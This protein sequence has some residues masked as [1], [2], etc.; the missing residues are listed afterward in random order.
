MRDEHVVQLDHKLL[1]EMLQSA[2]FS[3]DEILALEY[4]TASGQHIV[5]AK[6]DNFP[7]FQ[8]TN[9]Q[10]RHGMGRVGPGSSL[11]VQVTKK[12]ATPLPNNSWI[13][14]S[15]LR[16]SQC[17]E[18]ELVA[19][20]LQLVMACA[21][22]FPGEHAT[23]RLSDISAGL[24][25]AR[26][27][28]FFEPKRTPTGIPLAFVTIVFNGIDFLG[29]HYKVFEEAASR[30]GV[31]FEWHIVEGVAEGRADA[32]KP[33]SDTS[34][35]A[36]YGTESNLSTDGT[37]Q[38]LDSISKKHRN[39][40]VYR[41][42]D[43]PFKDKI[44]QIN[45]A[46]SHV[47]KSMLMQVDVDELWSTDAIV[48]AYKVL[49][50]PKEARKCMM[51]SCHFFVGPGRVVVRGWGHGPSEW[52]RAWKFEPGSFF[53]SH[54]PPVL[55]SPN[56]AGSLEEI[57]SC[58]SKE[59]TKQL[60]IG[61]SHYAYMFESQVQFKEEFY[62]YSEAV[63][64]W[65]ALQ[66]AELPVK[67]NQY[68]PW[69][70][71]GAPNYEPRFEE[72]L[73]VN[74]DD[75]DLTKSIDVVELEW[76]KEEGTDCSLTVMVDGVA[77]QM[78][79]QGG[80]ARVWSEVLPKVVDNLEGSCFVYLMRG[81]ERIPEA[82][83]ES[84]GRRVRHV[85][86][87]SFP[88]DGNYKAL[89]EDT[90]MLTRLAEQYGA[91]LFISTEYTFPDAL[92]IPTV[93]LVHDL[94][95]EVF[96]WSEDY[97]KL[98][99]EAIERASSIVT[100][101]KST[102]EKLRHFYRPAVQV[103]SSRNG[104]DP[105]VFFKRGKEA[106][107]RVREEVNM[108]DGDYLL[109]V[110]QRGGYKSTHSLTQT[111]RMSM[112]GGKVSARPAIIFVGGGSFTDEEVASL[113]GLAAYH[114]LSPSDDTLA[115]LYSGAAALVYLSL[116]EGFGLPLIE[117]LACGCGVIASDIEVFREV[118]GAYSDSVLFVKPDDA[119]GIVGAVHE[120]LKK[121]VG[122]ETMVKV[123]DAY[124]VGWVDLADTVTEA[125][126]EIV[127]G[128]KESVFVS[129]QGQDVW[130]HDAFKGLRGPAGGRWFV[131][132]GAND[133][134][135]LSNT[136]GLEKCGGWFGVCIEP[137]AAFDDL[138]ASG[139]VKCNKV[140]EAIAGNARKATLVGSKGAVDG[141]ETG[142]TLWAGLT[143]HFVEKAT[144]GG[145]FMVRCV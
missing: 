74:V 18:S 107:K 119:A 8:E 132:L 72:S 38:F 142:G 4:H 108:G 43:G 127:R 98:K 20:G 5:H 79:P 63:Q 110:G 15:P 64:G 55:V 120:M 81:Q 36:K 87:P 16:S 101:S 84:T 115:A 136:F 23:R 67:A 29:H 45:S 114:F 71:K 56:E 10:R 118:V 17:S 42:F 7:T 96:G 122:E 21:I 75:S 131:E 92:S 88:E 86:V 22:T 46:L 61:F 130:V 30:L 94:T 1:T 66:E 24:N 2:G 41:K 52:L 125:A 44:E 19:G 109:V 105:S 129:Q 53:L 100:V 78:K 133:G 59:E 93:L 141:L 138:M 57:K 143:E 117:A 28:S 37:S 123:R 26:L 69:L 58:V 70:R 33:Y 9:V 73:V 47:P 128:C 121:R 91:D 83:P 48:G 39:V 13:G 111:L 135:T 102:T 12:Y 40:K 34:L 65:K 137:T 50:A 62:G 85:T 95:P 80:I 31:E 60:G 11:I 3:E 106:I 90:A 51:F 14:S 54:A 77:F 144:V 103:R 116:D 112:G 89:K 49:T 25:L 97:W 104:L 27:S 68:L 76:V 124:G 6:A 140:R 134:V 35:G 145:D 82:L 126:E 113:E 139:R 99:H 32:R